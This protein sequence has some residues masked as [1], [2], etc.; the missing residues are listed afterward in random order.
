MVNTVFLGK[1]R[2]FSLITQL[3][4]Q[5]TFIGHRTKTSIRFPPARETINFS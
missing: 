3:V 5:M 2:H 1:K 4:V